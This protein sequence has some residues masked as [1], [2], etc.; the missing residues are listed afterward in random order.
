MRSHYFTERKAKAIEKNLPTIYR[1]VWKLMYSTGLRIGDAVAI[2]ECDIDSKGY[3]HY[4]AQKT[5]KVARVKLSDDLIKELR[6]NS[7][8]CGT[9]NGFV[10]F[11]PVNPD[12]H[13]SRQAVWK[14][15]KK[16]CRNIGI[17]PDGISPHSC[18]KSY[19]VKTYHE[20]GLS[21]VMADLQHSSPATTFLYC[22]DDNPLEDV[23]KRLK[24]AETTIKELKKL[25]KQVLYAV[26]LCLGKLIGDDRYGITE[27]GLA[28]L[29]LDNIEKIE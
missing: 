24:R 12:A 13:I 22:F 26:D 25:L 3:L 17:N 28:A 7:F 5:G 19:A 15:I 11:S 14:N 16:A 1:L 6:E 2:R 21:Q 29:D 9:S 18:R 23:N 4:T 27:A 20:K 10:F 8:L